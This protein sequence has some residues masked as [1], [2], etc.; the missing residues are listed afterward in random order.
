LEPSPE[1]KKEVVAGKYIHCD[2]GDG[3]PLR[4]CAGC[5][6]DLRLLGWGTTPGVLRVLTGTGW[7]SQLILRDPKPYTYNHRS[8][9]PKPYVLK[10]RE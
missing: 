2:F 6:L 8:L 5:C 3:A 4:E 9:N 10:D 1:K 7:L